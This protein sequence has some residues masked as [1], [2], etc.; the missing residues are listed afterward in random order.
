MTVAFVSWP[1]APL[2]HRLVIS[3]LRKIQREIEIVN[4]L[5]KNQYDSLIQWSTYDEIDHELTNA[6]RESVLASSYTFRKAI[7]RK[8]YLAHSI[9]AYLTKNPA[10][11]LQKATP[12][13]YNLDLAFADE[14]EEKWSDDLYDL[15]DLLENNPHTWWILKPFVVFIDHHSTH[16]SYPIIWKWHGRPGDG[17]TSIQ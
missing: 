17:H 4:S 2:T 10:S 5:G 13:T 7:I 16:L 14:L 15:G 3:A 6:R 12:Q 8:N 9:Y 1:S 11:I